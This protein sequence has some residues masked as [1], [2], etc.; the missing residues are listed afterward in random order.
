MISRSG[1]A[2]V[3]PPKRLLAVTR[4]RH[5]EAVEAELLGERDQQT[6]VVVHEQDPWGRVPVAPRRPSR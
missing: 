4:G 6:P 2:V 5:V 3:E 1:Q